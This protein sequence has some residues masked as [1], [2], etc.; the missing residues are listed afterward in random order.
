[1]FWKIAG[2]DFPI[3][4]LREFQAGG[5]SLLISGFIMYY[6]LKQNYAMAERYAWFE[7]FISCCYYWLRLM[8]DKDG[9]FY[10]NFYIFP[11]LAF[12]YILPWSVKNCARSIEIETQNI[13]D[14]IE[15]NKTLEGKLLDKD[16]YI[17]QL[18]KEV[19]DRDYLLRIKDDFIKSVA[20]RG[21]EGKKI[22]VMK[23]DKVKEHFK[24]DLESK[25]GKKGVLDFNDESKSNA[26]PN[27]LTQIETAKDIQKKRGWKDIEDEESFLRN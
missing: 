10:F 5:V 8:F 3:E 19:K 15:L 6:T 12:A 13:N 16:I 27:H 1:V 25:I 9:N 23:Q 18:E 24:N 21:T 22:K 7:F 11:G 26:T 4:Y 2:D 17:D 14:V 20:S